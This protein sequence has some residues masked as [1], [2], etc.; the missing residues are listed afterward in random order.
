MSS[1]AK[2]LLKH[3]DIHAIITGY[4]ITSSLLLYIIQTEIDKKMIQKP[5]AK[6]SASG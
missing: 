1:I 4:L 5:D 6:K 2:Q 3:I